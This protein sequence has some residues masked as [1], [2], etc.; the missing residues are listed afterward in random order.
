M[1]KRTKNK[2]TTKQT[3][4]RAAVLALA[5]FGN[6]QLAGL[7]AAKESLAQQ[8]LP[9]DRV[10]SFTARRPIATSPDPNENVV[11]VGV[12]EKVVD[13]KYTG[14][15]AVKLLVRF[16][17]GENQIS[18]EHRLPSIFNGFPT[19]VEEVG[20]FRRFEAVPAAEVFPDPRTRIDPA[21]P[22]CSIGFQDPANQFVMAG[23]F[24]A[25]VVRGEQQF[26]LSNNHVLADENN[27]PTGS[28]I[29]QPGF[30]DAG[31]P[32]N[33]D[34]IGQLAQFV[35]LQAGSPNSVD[36][37]IAAVSNP[38]LVT[39]SILRIG[40]PQGNAAAQRDMVVEKF[41]RTTGY[42]VG[43]VTSVNTDV[44]VEYN[45]GELVFQRQIIIKG[46][47]NQAFSAAGDSG[48]LIV[49]RSTGRAVGL[50]FAGSSTNTIANHIE[51][52]LHEL[53][54]ELV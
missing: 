22:G 50:L 30:L 29:F 43:R 17:Y 53:N 6:D 9:A 35:E 33:N 16:K 10:R 44:I 37:A 12:G 31:N 42:T 15:M 27:L 49:E 1:P 32:P 14:V 19:D 26:I 39:N 20:T 11:G 3:S 38:A 8:L 18:S 2:F 41:G 13:G 24:G 23:T 7:V 40:P 54:V 36:A 5:S 28:A 52:V 47:N 21:P 4:P 45:V 46:L 25:L 34:Q 51:D 48:S